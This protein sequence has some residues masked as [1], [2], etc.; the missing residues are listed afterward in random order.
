MLAVRFCNMIFAKSF[1]RHFLGT[2]IQ[3]LTYQRRAA[4]VHTALQ[5]A[6]LI[7]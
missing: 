1:V 5:P 2:L 7:F 6:L 4:S 3:R